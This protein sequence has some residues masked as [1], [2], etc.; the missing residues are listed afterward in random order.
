MSLSRLVQTLAEPLR[1][2]SRKSKLDLLSRL[3]LTPGPRPFLEIGVSGSPGGGADFFATDSR[4][5]RR[6]IACAYNLSQAQRFAAA[7]ATTTTLTADGCDLPFVDNS[8]ALAVA[9][10]VIEHVGSRDRQRRLVAEMLRV[11]ERVCVATPNRWFPVDLHTYLPLLHFLPMPLRNR[12]YRWLGHAAWATEAN[13]NLLSARQ[14]R[15]L[16]PVNSKTS[17][18]RLRLLGLTHSLVLVVQR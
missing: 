11:A 5:A 6:V 18:I 10:A 8:F 7:H 9:N 4:Y 1:L 13:L 14:L 12:L 17:L 15:S 2:R 3:I 16:A